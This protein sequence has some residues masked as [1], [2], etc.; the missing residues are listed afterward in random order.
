MNSIF[1]NCCC[2]WAFLDNECQNSLLILAINVFNILQFISYSWEQFDACIGACD[3]SVVDHGPYS[4][5]GVNHH[6]YLIN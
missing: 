6:S 4:L 2:L 3:W 5:V 1:Q